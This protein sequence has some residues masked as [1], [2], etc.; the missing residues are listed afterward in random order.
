MTGIPCIFWYTVCRLGLLCGNPAIGFA[1]IQGA[2]IQG[3]SA[4]GSLQVGG[5]AE[6]VEGLHVGQGGN[7]AGRDDRYG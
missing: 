2:F 4:D 5:A 7:T 3:A 1:Q 6:R